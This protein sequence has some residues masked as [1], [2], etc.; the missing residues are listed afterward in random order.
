LCHLVEFLEPRPYACQLGAS[1][2]PAA[3]SRQ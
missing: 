2:R 3:K 1:H